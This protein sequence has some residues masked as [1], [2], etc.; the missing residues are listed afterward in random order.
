MEAL[1]FAL[2]TRLV[3]L[4]I[5]WWSLRIF[6]KHAL[7]PVQL[8]DQ[9]FPGNLVLDGWARWDTAHYVAIAAQGYGDDNPSPHGGLG[10]FPLFPLLM[11]GAVEAV[12]AAPT[13]AHL[14]LAALVI[15]NLCFVGCVALVA[16]FAA[17]LGSDASRNATV[18]L[19][20]SPFSFFFDVAYTESFFL[21]LSLGACALAERRQWLF[22]SGLAAL[23]SGTR[24]VGLAVAPAVLWS[25]WRRGASRREL[26]SI[27][28]ISP[29]GAVAYSIYTLWKFDDA[30]AYF[31]AQATWGGWD[32]HVRFYAELFAKHPREALTGD[33]RHLVIVLNL[34]LGLLALALLP[35]VW[36]V[37]EP[38]LAVFTIL[39][40]VVQFAF[41][42]VSLGRYLLP[43]AGLY[44]AAA[45]I[46]VLPAWRSWP[47][48]AAIAVSTLLLATLTILFAHG[49]WIV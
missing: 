36:K 44:L 24:L 28:A 33:P 47:R 27:A 31:N 49:F 14:A 45:S 12:R 30:F 11:R 38:G 26:I 13:D 4:G 41:T 32:E 1:A 7:Y 15:A 21:L 17:H 5:A 22:A 16:M 37:A 19:C 42:W 43:A 48:D 18:L 9:F 46:L 34:A 8:P 35:R 3:L 25:A 6:G 39:L 29:L 2:V 40:V 23:A 10:F 20:L